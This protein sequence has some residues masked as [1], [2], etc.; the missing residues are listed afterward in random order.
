MAG[1]GHIPPEI[2]HL[3]SVLKS[4]SAIRFNLKT[5]TYNTLSL[6][7]FTRFVTAIFANPSSFDPTFKSKTDAR[8][9]LT[10]KS[11]PFSQM[12]QTPFNRLPLNKKYEP[13]QSLNAKL[14]E[15]YFGQLSAFLN[16]VAE[17]PAAPPNYTKPSQEQLVE[18]LSFILERVCRNYDAL[19][20][21]Y[22]ELMA[23]PGRNPPTTW[24]IGSWLIQFMTEDRT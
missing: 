14:A 23:T 7:F 10:T 3:A 15:P 9:F 13:L 24:A 8:A 12:M 16:K 17:A 1:I 6:F 22:S 5:A 18:S 20:A 21:K 19:A 11:I 2:H 4:C